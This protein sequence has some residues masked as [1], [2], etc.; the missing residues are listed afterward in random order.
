MLEVMHK[1]YLSHCCFFSLFDRFFYNYLYVD[2]FCFV[3]W[4]LEVCFQCFLQAVCFACFW[5]MYLFIGC[6]DLFYH[7]F[8][9]LDCCWLVYF[10]WF[11]FDT[12]FQMHVCGVFDMFLVL[13]LSVYC[14]RWIASKSQRTEKNETAAI[15][16]RCVV[17]CLFLYVFLAVYIFCF[18]RLVLL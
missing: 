2:I 1:L 16:F 13:F 10:V 3:F 14:C 12:V 17:C 15:L 11:V 7:L 4:M 6:W 8:D 9:Q 5:N 18:V